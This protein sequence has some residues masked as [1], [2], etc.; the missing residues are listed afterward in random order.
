MFLKISILCSYLLLLLSVPAAIIDRNKEPF[1]GVLQDRAAKKV[2]STSTKKTSSTSTTAKSS[3]KSTIK[4][5]LTTSSSK[6]S[7]LAST[8]TT[9][10]S[11]STSLVA[12][13]SCTNGPFTRQCWGNGFSIATDYDKSWPVTGKI[14]QVGGPSLDLIEAC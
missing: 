14:V 12:D 9:S 7:S 1:R 2:T 3:S 6:S 11:S 8:K 5:T 13:S 4:T 10:A